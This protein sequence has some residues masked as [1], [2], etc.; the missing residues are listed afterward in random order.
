MTLLYILIDVYEYTPINNNK[1]FN[2]NYVIKILLYIVA[3]EF[4]G[5][6]L[7]CISGKKSGIVIQDIN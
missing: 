3:N 1:N 6:I 5:I 4:Y 2:Y 7:N